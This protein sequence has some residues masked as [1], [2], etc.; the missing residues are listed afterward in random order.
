M[1]FIKRIQAALDIAKQCL[2]LRRRKASIPCNGAICNRSEQLIEARMVD[3]LD[4][5]M[6]AN[7]EGDDLFVIVRRL[8][9]AKRCATKTTRPERNMSS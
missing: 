1:H 9:C 8:Q 7:Q 4:T 2:A 6:S 5:R 3:R